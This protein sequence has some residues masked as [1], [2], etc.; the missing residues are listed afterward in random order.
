MINAITPNL[1]LDRTLT[2]SQEVVPGTLMRPSGV[3]ETAGGKGVNLVRAVTRLGGE[4]CI[5]GFTSGWNGKKWRSLCEV[6]ELRYKTIELTGETRECQIFIDPEGIATEVY[7]PGPSASL[8]NFRTLLAG[9]FEG[10]YVF[11]GS[12][13][14]GIRD[15]TRLFELLPKD[16]VV[17]TSGPALSYAVRHGVRLIAPNRQELA[18]LLDQTTASVADAQALYQT[19]GTP[20][21]LTLGADGATYVG[22]CV[23][24]AKPPPITVSNPVGSGDCLLGAFLLAWSQGKP[25]VEALRFGVAAGTDNARRSGGGRITAKSVAALEKHITTEDIG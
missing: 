21:L 13:P 22:E 25:L 16:C 5:Y 7:E 24:T 9:L 20:I 14:T 15:F 11:T 10:I 2:L 18:A 17:D 19:C 3:R 6:E 4:A 8:S 1:A 23:I 12:I